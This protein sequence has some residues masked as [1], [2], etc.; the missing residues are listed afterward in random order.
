MYV[1]MHK[2]IKKTFLFLLET[3]VFLLKKG[4]CV[5]PLSLFGCVCVSKK[6]FEDRRKGCSRKQTRRRI[7]R[8]HNTK[9]DSIEGRSSR[10][11]TWKWQF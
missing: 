6:H 1:C 8:K 7:G 3:F 11:Q 9:E 2:F 5:H 10:L 4:Q